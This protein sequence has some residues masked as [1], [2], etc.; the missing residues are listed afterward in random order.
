MW[1]YEIFIFK[2]FLI[3]GT[4]SL[5]L[6]SGT[7]AK[8]NIQPSTV[9]VIGNGPKPLLCSKLALFKKAWQMLRVLLHLS[10]LGSYLPLLTTFQKDTV[11]PCTSRDIENTKVQSW[12][13]WI[14]YVKIEFSTMT[15]HI[16]DTPWCSGSYSISLERSQ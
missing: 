13:I 5:F 6:S 11:W 12:N 8:F 15:C 1:N 3:H 9:L 16:F 10:P 2:I 7:V 14:Y 4:W